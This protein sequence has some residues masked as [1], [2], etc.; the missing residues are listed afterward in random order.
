MCPSA[1]GRGSPARP[2]TARRG[3]KAIGKVE[4]VGK[5]LALL[6]VGLAPFVEREVQRAV[7]AR[8]GIQTIRNHAEDP[9]L[10]KKS[11]GEWDAAALLT[12]TWEAWNDS[13]NM[14]GEKT[15]SQAL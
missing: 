4:D 8:L 2:A 14:R 3:Q 13:W 15:K 5:A 12:L 9:N 7:K 1:P 11:V 6:G 10:A